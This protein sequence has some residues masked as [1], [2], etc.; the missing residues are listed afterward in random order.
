MEFDFLI[1]AVNKLLETSP[2]QQA[3]PSPPDNAK[4][5][6][7]PPSMTG[8]PYSDPNAGMD[9]GGDMGGDPSMGGGMDQGM[10]GGMGMPGEEQLKPVDINR[11]YELKKIHSRLVTI[12]NLLATSEDIA[13]IK[14][15]QI[16]LQASDLFQH[17]ILNFDQ[18]KE[19]IDDIIIEFYKFLD[20]LYSTIV[21][22]FKAA[23]EE[24]PQVH[25]KKV[26]AFLKK[27]DIE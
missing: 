2:D 25:V 19:R 12:E 21:D 14:V 16:I 26:D 20:Y 22:Y 3:E 15:K 27:E 18:Y 5:P 9:A 1:E 11:M 24:D 10:G 13:S 8:D 23:S 4:D 7:S 17:V 6:T